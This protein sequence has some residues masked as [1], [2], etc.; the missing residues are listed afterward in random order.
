MLDADNRR[1]TAPDQ[2]G[3]VCVRG[4]ALALGYYRNPEQTQKAFVQNPLQS[5][6]PEWIYRTGDLAYYNAG[7]ELV[8]CGRKDFQIKYMGHRIELEEIERAVSA[9]PGVARCCVVF[10]E[11][12][13]RLYGFYVGTVA[14]TEL[15]EALKTVLPAYMIPTS[16]EPLEAFPLTANGKVD[17]KQL[18]ERKVSRCKR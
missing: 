6:Y 13:Q 2:K 10:H 17:R 1:I 4:T 16:L 8:F 11:A 12:K 14:H 7:G 18:L 15:V 3:E 9:V 5:A